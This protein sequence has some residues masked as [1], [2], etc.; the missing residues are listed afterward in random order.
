MMSVDSNFNFLCG[1]PHGGWTP[2]PP[3]TCIHLSLTPSPLRVDVINGWPL[4]GL[5][6]M[7]YSIISFFALSDSTAITPCLSCNDIGAVI[8][9]VVIRFVK[10]QVIHD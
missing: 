10:Y 5:L 3:S 2:L 7:S 8:I 4:N 1:R 6:S 9:D